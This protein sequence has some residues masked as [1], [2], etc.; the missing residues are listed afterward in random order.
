[1]RSLV[2]TKGVPQSV[3][4]VVFAWSGK[5]VGI[6]VVVVQDWTVSG[7]KKNHSWFASVC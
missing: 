4:A 3:F 5:V 1:M 7:E 6:V 2:A